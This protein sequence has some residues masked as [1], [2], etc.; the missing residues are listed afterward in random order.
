MRFIFLIFVFSVILN[1][2]V[3]SQV[4]QNIRVE[5]ERS[6]KEGDKEEVVKGIIYYQTPG[7]VFVIIKDPI[8]QW[9]LLEK[10]ELI[11]Y[12]P[13][14]T[15]AIRFTTP[16]PVSLSFFQPFLSV[17]KDDYGLTGMGFT[18]YN[19]RI[20]GDTL[21][22]YWSPPNKLSKVMSNLI[23]VYV[24]DRIACSE[25]KKTD[26]TTIIKSSFSN[27]IPYEGG[28]FPLQISMVRYMGADSTFERI[29]YR[30]PQFNISIPLEV[31]DFKIPS[32]VEIEE[33][34]W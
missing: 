16:H 31:R 23:L 13:I 32:Y 12:Y 18:L 33:I 5:F 28:Y 8:K 20:S 1:G 26:G 6:F 34:E 24:A 27:H 25:L 11:I 19:H 17:M 14:D 3:Y 21:S 10:N 29:I 7:R 4:L 22:T 9:M 15:L 30:N 2:N